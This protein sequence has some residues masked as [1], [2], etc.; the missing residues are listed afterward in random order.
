M[1]HV[2][3]VLLFVAG[4]LVAGTSGYADVPPPHCCTKPVSK[5]EQMILTF[6]TLIYLP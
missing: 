2:R 1:R 6:R 5:L 3:L 4:S